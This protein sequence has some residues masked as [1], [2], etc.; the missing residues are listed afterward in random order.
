LDGQRHNECEGGDVP[1]DPLGAW[2]NE[3]GWIWLTAACWLLILRGPAFVENLRTTGGRI[4][5]FFQEYASARNWLEGLPIYADHHR[6]AQRYLHV[7]LDDKRAHVFANAHPPTSVLFA[8]PFARLDFRDAF[9]AWNLVSLS[10]LAAS[11][12]IV[13]RQLRIPASPWSVAPLLS[14]LLLCHPLWEQS[15]LGQLTLVLLLL[16]TGAWAAE[17]SG[18]PGMAGALLGTA[19]AIKLFPAFLFLYFALRGHWRVVAA[20]LV[21]IAGLTGLTVFLLGLDSYRSYFLTV[22]PEIQWFRVGWNNDSFWGFW[23]RFFDP[24]PEHERDRSLTEPFY[25]SPALATALSLTS[26]AAVTAILAW[27]VRRDVK[28]EGCDLTFAL[29]ATAM[30]L[31]SPICWDHYLL[32]LLVPLAVVWMQLP[33][34]WFARG[35]F[36]AIVIAFW[37]GYPVVW[38]TF[39]LN[40]RTARPIDS[41]GALSY[42]FYALL[43]F[44]ALVLVELGIGN[45]RGA[46]AQGAVR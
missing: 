24:A 41:L 28:G 33:E 11:L 36:L 25:Y 10:A 2:P 43:G 9:F 30:L 7:S 14:L 5:D 39:D 1:W 21:T 4:P 6:T 16:F 18:R 23:S 34:S 3:R 42:Q 38:T 27:A 17:R 8:L 13:Q 46:L 12:W 15:R 45:G 19:S 29:A 35:I 44:F 26:S 32:L 31:V 20:G 40:G 22:L 37:V